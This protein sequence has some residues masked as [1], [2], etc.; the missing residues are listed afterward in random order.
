MDDQGF[1]LLTAK[2]AGEILGVNPV[3]ITRWAKAEHLPFVTVPPY[4]KRMYRRA[5]VEE[6]AERRRDAAAK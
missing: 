5:D 6:L 4:D 2:Q 1:D 3:T